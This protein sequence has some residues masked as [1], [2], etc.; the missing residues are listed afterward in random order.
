MCIQVLELDLGAVEKVVWL[1]QSRLLLHN[2]MDGCVRVRHSP[3]VSNAN[4]KMTA[5][6]GSVM[7]W[8]MFC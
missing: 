3:W 2:V 7:L 6:K 4:R 5:G 8:A 1:Y